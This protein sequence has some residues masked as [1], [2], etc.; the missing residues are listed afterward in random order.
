MLKKI[1]QQLLVRSGKSYQ[2]SPQIP[3][4][5]IF[6]TFCLRFWMLFRGTVFLQRKVFLGSNV[7]VLNKSN[8]IFGKNVTIEAYTI[9]DGYASQKIVLGDNVKIGMYSKLLSTSHLATYGKGL[10]MG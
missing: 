7:K 8:F 6:R 3:D 10:K 4:S 2:I 1:L 5:L 9:L